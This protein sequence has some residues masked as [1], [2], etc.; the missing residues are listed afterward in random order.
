MIAGGV[1][2]SVPKPKT[3]Q[4]TSKSSTTKPKQ[5]TTTVK[6][7][8]GVALN[9]NVLTSSDRLNADQVQRTLTNLF[10]IRHYDKVEVVY[11]GRPSKVRNCPTGIKIASPADHYKAYLCTKLDKPVKTDNENND[12]N[13]IDLYQKYNPDLKFKNLKPRKDIVIVIDGPS[14]DKSYILAIHLFKEHYLKHN[15]DSIEVIT[16]N[17]LIKIGDIS[18]LDEVIGQKIN[19]FSL[20]DV[21]PLIGSPNAL[22]GM[23]FG[24]EVAEYEKLFNKCDYKLVHVSDPTVKILNAKPGDLIL[25][26]RSCF[27]SSAY[28]EVTIRRVVTVV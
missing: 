17:R 13:F 23:A 24:Y 5:Q 27:E 3:K 6:S 12:S 21:Y 11:E 25:A 14:Y 15:P 8:T 7:S 16:T 28:L 10:K 4:T 18:V 22:Y 26:I 19:V 2:K 20:F 1:S 9:T